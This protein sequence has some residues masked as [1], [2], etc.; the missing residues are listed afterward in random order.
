M[1]NFRHQSRNTTSSLLRD[2]NN[3][4]IEKSKTLYSNSSSNKS[5]NHEMTYLRTGR[6]RNMGYLKSFFCTDTKPVSRKN[7]GK[8]ESEKII[9][10]NEQAT[11]GIH[12]CRYIYLYL[13]K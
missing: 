6:I 4:T 7:K 10:F 11:I 3:D 8:T 9:G 5:V 13:H 2:N 1:K 12:I